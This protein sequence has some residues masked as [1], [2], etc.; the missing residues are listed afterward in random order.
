MKEQKLVL[1]NIDSFK[2]EDIYFYHDK[3]DLPVLA[4]IKYKNTDTGKKQFSQANIVDCGDY[5]KLDYKTEKIN[6]I[7]NMPRVVKSIQENKD[8][9]LQQVV[10]KTKCGLFIL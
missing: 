7:Y 9:M 8:I 5:Y 1:K 4:R 6:L 3:D 2:L 10:L